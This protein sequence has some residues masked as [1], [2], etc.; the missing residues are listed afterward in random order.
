MIDC[1]KLGKDVMAVL[2]KLGGDVTI[3]VQNRET[4]VRFFTKIHG[5]KMFR[6]DE[7]LTIYT[8]HEITFYIPYRTI[9]HFI[10]HKDHRQLDIAHDWRNVLTI[11]E[12]EPDSRNS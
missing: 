9:T 10:T 5:C 7:A 4:N 12:L 11:R 6:N 3:S 1:V 2:E 8:P